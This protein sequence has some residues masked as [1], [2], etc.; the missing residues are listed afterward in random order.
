M[1]LNHS[2]YV[3]PEGHKIAAGVVDELLAD[4][5]AGAGATRC[6]TVY[7]DSS[8]LRLPLLRENAVNA[9]LTDFG[10]QCHRR[11]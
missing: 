2:A 11:T 3:V 6:L 1:D 5:L 4:G 10:E 9:T 8:L 7:P